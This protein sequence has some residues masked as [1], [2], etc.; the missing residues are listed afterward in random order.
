MSTQ[1]RA[2]Y[3][4]VIASRLLQG[5]SWRSKNLSVSPKNLSDTPESPLNSHR[6]FSGFDLHLT[7][8]VEGE[9]PLFENME[10]EVLY[11]SFKE[12]YPAVEMMYKTKGGMLYGLQVTRQQDLTRKIKTSAVDQLLSAVGLKDRREKIRIAVIPKPGLVEKFNAVY[13]GEAEGYPQL[14]LWSVPPDYS[15]RF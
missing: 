8:L 10:S 14:E 1:C 11:K 9:P 4:E 6:T 7:K 5:V 2:T 15:L 3:E 12:N 13:V